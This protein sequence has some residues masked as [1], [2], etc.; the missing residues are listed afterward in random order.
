[1]SVAGSAGALEPLQRVLSTLPASLPA[2][3]AVVLHRGEGSRVAEALAPRSRLPVRDA[4]SGEL[5]REGRVHVAPACTHL[6]VNPDGQVKVSFGGRARR[7]RPSADWLFES[8]AASY[9][10]RHIA[11]VLSGAL[12]DGAARLRMVKRLGGTVIVQ[13]PED[14]KRADMPR[15][16]IATGT[17]DHVVRVDALAGTIADAV[18]RCARDGDLVSWE[19]PFRCG[20]AA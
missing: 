15:A 3:V 17:A 10:E 14:A 18:H 12:W 1:V 9:R 19:H 7:F 11:V 5:L 13:S 20:T 16:A 8:A 2:A 6:V 4:Q